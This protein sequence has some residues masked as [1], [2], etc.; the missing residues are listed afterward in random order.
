MQIFEPLL[1]LLYR[2][3]IPY[4][5]KYIFRKQWE[6]YYTLYQDVNFEKKVACTNFDYNK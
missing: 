5:T 6:E 3:Y 2:E 4:S 1:R